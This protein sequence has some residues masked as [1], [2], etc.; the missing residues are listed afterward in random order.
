MFPD[1]CLSFTD[2][3]ACAFVVYV[4]LLV[5]CE[6]EVSVHQVP[7]RCRDLLFPECLLQFTTTCQSSADIPME[8]FPPSD[9][10]L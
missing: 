6:C 8:F 5:L 4:L 1:Q 10:S 9:L 2:Y 7:F 3:P